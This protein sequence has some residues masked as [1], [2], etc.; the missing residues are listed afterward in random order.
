LGGLAGADAICQLLAEDAGIGGTFKAWLSD[1]TT[2]ARDRLTHAT[3]PYERV[4]GIHV[5]ANWTDLTD[6]RLAATIGKTE[7]NTGVGGFVW[8]STDPSGVV[9]GS[10]CLSWSTAAGNM[11]GEVGTPQFAN[12]FWTRLTPSGVCEATT[13]TGSTCDT[14]LRLYCIEQ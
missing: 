12:C 6:G 2:D 9:D 1:S 10:T 11:D 13:P 14:L 7:Q 3:V 4:D 5:A 8:T